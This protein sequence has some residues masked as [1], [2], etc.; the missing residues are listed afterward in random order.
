[1]KRFIIFFEEND[2][3]NL[4]DVTA[5]VAYCYLLSKIDKIDDRELAYLIDIVRSKCD[6]NNQAVTTLN[7]LVDTIGSADKL[8]KYRD[9]IT[10][11]LWAVFE[12]TLTGKENNYFT[13][14]VLDDVAF[15]S[16]YDADYNNDCPEEQHIICVDSPVS[17]RPSKHT[18]KED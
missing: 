10:R 18:K 6:F 15:R 2:P 8:V 4:A 3:D 11:I 5:P 16:E 9:I 7:D 1:M 12:D 13:T 17:V 14:A